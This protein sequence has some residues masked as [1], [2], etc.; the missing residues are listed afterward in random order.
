MTVPD[1]VPTLEP[2]VLGLYMHLPEEAT[3]PRDYYFSPL[4]DAMIC[5]FQKK[6]RAPRDNYL[7]PE[8]TPLFYAILLYYLICFK[9]LGSIWYPLNMLTRSWT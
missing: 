7:M 8:I 5:T 1:C 6:Q 9:A 4:Y 3:H 2:A